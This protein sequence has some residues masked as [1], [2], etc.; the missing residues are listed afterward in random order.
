[1][2]G[3]LGTDFHEYGDS[4]SEATVD[5]SEERREGGG[6]GGAAALEIMIDVFYSE[7]LNLP[8]MYLNIVDLESGDIVTSKLLEG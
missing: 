4:D 8:D 2:C 6:V 1:M 3:A 7:V 5:F